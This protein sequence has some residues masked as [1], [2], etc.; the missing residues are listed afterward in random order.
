MHYLEPMTAAAVAQPDMN[1][2]ADLLPLFNNTAPT[3]AVLLPT[4]GPSESTLNLVRCLVDQDDV[5]VVVIDDCTPTDHDGYAVIEQIQELT[6]QRESLVYLRTETNS[7]KAGALNCGL[8][9]VLDLSIEPDYIFTFDDDVEIFPE[10]LSRMIA[11][12]EN[13]PMLGAV[14]THALVKNRSHNLITRLQSLEYHTFNITKQADNSFLMGP[15]VMQGML[16]AFRTEAIKAVGGFSLHHL[17]EDYDITARLKRQGWRVGIAHDAYALT[18]VPETFEQL[19]RQRTRWSYGGLKVALDYWRTPVIIMQDLIGHAMFVA[20]V[21]L[22]V[23]SLMFSQTA[24]SSQPLI[25]VLLGISLLNFFINVGFSFWTLLSYQNR[26]WQ[27]MVLKLS[28]F[29]EFIYSNVMT[30]ILIGSYFFM[31]YNL[32]FDALATIPK[33]IAWT[34][35]QVRQIGLLAFSRFGYSQ[36]WGT[37]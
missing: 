28:I 35:G 3:K 7:L 4:Y 27:D 15:L 25:M 8:Q 29:P 36:A 12:L 5:L 19:W 23:T 2:P 30:M 24:A 20:L 1:M 37:K 16:T 14:C 18:I 13:T 10:T 31:L 6:E 17:I 11:S 21:G 9:Y 34:L 26:D 22:I 32:L 33:A